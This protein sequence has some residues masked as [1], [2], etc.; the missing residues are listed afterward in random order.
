MPTVRLSALAQADLEEIW[1]FIA[2][3]DPLAADGFIERIQ[4]TCQQLARSPGMGRS[5][6]ELAEGIHSFPVGKYLVFYRRAGTGIEVARLLSGYR[7][8]ETLFG[9]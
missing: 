4:R 6:E 8:I 2:R 3:D 5:R 7:D 1:L 9:L